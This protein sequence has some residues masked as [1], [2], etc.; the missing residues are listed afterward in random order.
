MCL[1]SFHQ[2][3]KPFQ[4]QFEA[5]ALKII[6]DSPALMEALLEADEPYTVQEARRLLN[7]GADRI[8]EDHVGQQEAIINA[9]IAY[10]EKRSPAKPKRSRIRWIR[11]MQEAEEIV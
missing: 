3:L 5:K 1:P 9:V 7:V 2:G 11:R 4:R 10:A 8:Y 6:D